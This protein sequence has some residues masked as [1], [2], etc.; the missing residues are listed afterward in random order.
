MKSWSLA[1]I[2]SNY[3]KQGHLSKA[4]ALLPRI[5][6]PTHKLSALRDI[7]VGFAEADKIVKARQIFRKLRDD[8][9]RYAVLYAIVEAHLRA[10]N[11]AEAQKIANRIDGEFYSPDFKQYALEAI[12]KAKTKQAKKITKS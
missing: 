9:D 4:L 10:G 3:A 12:A 8:Y 7:G 2:A 11:L 5:Q 1:E 6:R